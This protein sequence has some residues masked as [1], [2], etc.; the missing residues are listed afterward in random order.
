[1]KYPL[2]SISWNAKE[3]QAA[4]EVLSGDMYS[5]GKYTEEFEKNYAEWAGSKYAI[6]CNS[7]SSANLLALAACLYDPRQDLSVG[8]EVLVP[9][10]SWS[11]T[12]A[13]IQQM[14]LI[15]KL[16]DVSI[17]TYNICP[18]LL[19]QNIT[20]KSKAIFAVN[21]LGASCDYNKIVSLCDKHNLI[22]LEDN[23]ESMGASYENKKTGCFGLI[24]THSTFFSH[25]MATMEG[26]ICCTNDEL[27]SEIL[28][29]L[30]A[31]G[32]VRNVKNNDLFY[33]YFPKPSNQLEEKFHFVLP[34]FNF[35]PTEISAAIGIEQILKLDNFISNRREN[36]E[37]F[38]KKLKAV[39]NISLSL[40]TDYGKSSW[41]GFGLIAE[42]SEK[43]DI[44][45]D[46]LT[47][48]GIEVRPI[49]SGNMARQPMFSSLNLDPKSYVNA[50]II[51]SRGFMI[52]NH[53]FD[54]K[55]M[56]DLFFST[57][58]SI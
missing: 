13:P 56:I 52:G 45:L 7:G 54:I 38:I 1:M 27:L 14:G 16:V 6:F 33:K 51:H 39:T 50:E 5:M 53:Q 47:N 55:H 43:R 31:H 19:E 42:S 29:S 2:A 57:I 8:D 26:G 49:V 24:S 34:G 15:P 32:W 37:Y 9:S 35:R 23:C 25:H 11:T 40:Q 21:L 4:L 58:E 17:E 30:R 36:A 41:F 48:A 44:I 3:Y 46:S 12:Y 22:L 28:R 18:E 10:V 20:K